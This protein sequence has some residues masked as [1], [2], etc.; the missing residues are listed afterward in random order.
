MK[1]PRAACMDNLLGEAEKMSWTLPVGF[2]RARHGTM[3]KKAG[4]IE[5][6][7]GPEDAGPGVQRSSTVKC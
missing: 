5:A 2:D 6:H 1:D 7:V 3:K 4:S